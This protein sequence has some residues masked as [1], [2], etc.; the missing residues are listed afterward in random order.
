M[1]NIITFLRHG[2][3]KVDANV[4]I[5]KWVLSE[6]GEQQAKHISEL[7]DFQQFDVIIVSGEEK[8]FQTA[9]PLAKKLG[10][11]I[12]RIPELS[13]L[14]RDKKG[15]LSKD[16]YEEAAKEALAHPE[17][18]VPG[19]EPAAEA[20]ARFRTKVFEID[21]RYEGKRI[22]IVGHG[23]T[24]NLYFAELMGQMDKVYERLHQNSFASWGIVENGK[25]VRDLSPELPPVGEKLV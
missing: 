6:E 18:A 8:A 19:W 24:M 2:K 15:H 1:N 12:V 21:E 10:K 9:A 25:V 5:S 22:L 20:L 14:D 7:P 11:E 16:A 23:Y 17:K 13:E 4:P 3:T